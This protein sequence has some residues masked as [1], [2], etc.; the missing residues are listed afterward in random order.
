MSRTT[1]L[2]TSIDLLEFERGGFPRVDECVLGDFAEFLHPFIRYDHDCLDA[3]RLDGTSADQ[4]RIE[5]ARHR[6]FVVD[7]LAFAILDFCEALVA[8]ERHETQGIAEH[9]IGR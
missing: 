4:L 8:R 6:A 1:S 3:E 5:A 2:R 7:L 9:Q